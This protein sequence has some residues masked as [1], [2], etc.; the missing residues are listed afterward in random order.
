MKSGAVVVGLGWMEMFG[1]M[2][3][4]VVAGQHELVA[5]LVEAE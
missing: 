5:A 2:R 4:A 1:V 3:G